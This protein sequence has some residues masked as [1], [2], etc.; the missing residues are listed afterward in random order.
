MKPYEVRYDNRVGGRFGTMPFSTYTYLISSI[1]NVNKDHFVA[2]TIYSPHGGGFAEPS[3]N[4]VFQK[5]D[6][7]TPIKDYTV[8]SVS[9]VGY[10]FS[11]GYYFGRTSDFETLQDQ[12]INYFKSFLENE[13]TKIFAEYKAEDY[14]ELISALQEGFTNAISANKYDSNIKRIYTCDEGDTRGETN[15][16]Y[17]LLFRF[18]EAENLVWLVSLSKDTKTDTLCYRYTNYSNYSVKTLE[19]GDLYTEAEEKNFCAP[20]PD[21]IAAI[22]SSN[23]AGLYSPDSQDT[24]ATTVEQTN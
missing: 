5:E 4:Y 13:N 6:A 20:I 12:A 2:V 10:R 8:S 3:Q 23:W 15:I 18:N 24:E 21:D 17:S 16:Y 7:P 19:N 14:P 11:P 9:V 22:L 1:P